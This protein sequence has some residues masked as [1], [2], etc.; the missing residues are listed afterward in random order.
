MNKTR[1]KQAKLLLSCGRKYLIE[2]GLDKEAED[3]QVILT[4]LKAMKSKE[5]LEYFAKEASLKLGLEKQSVDFSKWWTQNVSP[6]FA[7]AGK[8][9]QTPAAQKA[10]LGGGIGLLGGSLL[11]GAIGRRPG[12][13]LAGGVLGGLAGGLGTHY[14]D[15]I[16][17]MLGW[18]T[19]TTA[20]TRA[21]PQQVTR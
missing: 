6:Y 16:R 4:L 3:P 11:G 13:A 7:S 21:T 10:L 2:M 9:L 1:E 18:K 8:W 20:A 19:P 12:S 15:D 17:K 14:W 5:G